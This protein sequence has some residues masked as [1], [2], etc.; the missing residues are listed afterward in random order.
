[1]KLLA[2]FITLSFSTSSFAKDLFCNLIEKP[3]SSE[4]RI[5]YTEDVPTAVALRSP[6]SEEFRQLNADVEVVFP[7]TPQGYESFSVKPRSTQEVDWSKEPQC[8]KEIGT[9]WYFMMYHGKGQ[10]LVQFLPHY[11]KQNERCV[12][13]RS[14]PQTQPLSCLY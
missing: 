5:T 10:Y 9:Q 8:F 4:L 3:D 7:D 1:M 12:L 6:G 2:L 14:R 11:I 13:P